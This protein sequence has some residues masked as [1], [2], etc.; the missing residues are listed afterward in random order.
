M[1]PQMRAAD[2]LTEKQAQALAAKA[3]TPA[4]HMKLAEYYK[5]EADKLDAT[6]KDHEALAEIYRLNPSQLGGGK[7]VGNP[8][9]RTA[10]HCEAI[11]KSLREAAKSTRELAAEHEQMAKDAS[12]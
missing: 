8:Q 9:S 5:L 12:K 10:E 6:A 7:S 4:D 11:A 3:K 2:Q 1:A